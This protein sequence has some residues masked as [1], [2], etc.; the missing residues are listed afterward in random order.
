MKY[1]KIYKKRLRKKALIKY[2]HKPKKR[3][4]IKPKKMVKQKNKIIKIIFVSMIF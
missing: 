3:F 4:S 1:H 2:L